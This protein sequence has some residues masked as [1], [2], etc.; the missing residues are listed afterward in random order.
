M[1]K[2]K[3]SCT[4]CGDLSLSPDDIILIRCSDGTGDSYRFEC[5]SCDRSHTRPLAENLTDLLE[6]V[7]VAIQYSTKPSVTRYGATLGAIS[8]DEIQRFVELTGDDA[9]FYADLHRFVFSDDQR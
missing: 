2:I 1:S 4:R 8:D 3:V 6:S 9:A 7:G 5:P